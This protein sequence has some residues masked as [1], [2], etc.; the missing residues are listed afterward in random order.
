MCNRL[1]G[2]R[3]CVSDGW[4]E[5]GA[6]LGGAAVPFAGLDQRRLAS[7]VHGPQ[8]QRTWSV[9][10]VWPLSAKCLG[11]GHV[12]F[13]VAG[14]IPGGLHQKSANLKSFC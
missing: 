4:D 5:L 9:Q 12:F 1:L 14:H 2:A 13:Q 7:A 10:L 11:E 8:V 6:L 3:S